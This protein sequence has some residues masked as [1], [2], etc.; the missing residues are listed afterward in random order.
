MDL[1]RISNGF[2]DLYTENLMKKERRSRKLRTDRKRKIPPE[3][4]PVNIKRSCQVI[5]RNTTDLKFKDS[6]S[7]EFRDYRIR[8]TQ[9]LLDKWRSFDPKNGIQRIDPT[10]K[11]EFH[12]FTIDYTQVTLPRLLEHINNCERAILHEGNF[13]QNRQVLM[14][15]AHVL[16]KAGR[17]WL[18]KKGWIKWEAFNNQDEQDSSLVIAREKTRRHTIM[19]K[20]PNDSSKIIETREVEEPTGLEFCHGY[21]I[22]WKDDTF[23]ALKDAGVSDEGFPWRR[24]YDSGKRLEITT[25]ESEH[26]YE[27]CE[28][29]PEARKKLIQLG[30][31]SSVL[32]QDSVGGIAIQGS[33]AEAAFLGIDDSEM[34]PE[35]LDFARESKCHEEKRR[36]V[37]R[38]RDL[39]RSRPGQKRKSPYSR[40][41]GG[42]VST[43]TKQPT[44][45]DLESYVSAKKRKQK[46]KQ[47]TAVKHH[48][49]EK[50]G[51]HER[52]VADLN[53]LHRA[54]ISV[55]AKRGGVKSGSFRTHKNDPAKPYIKIALGYIQSVTDRGIPINVEEVVAGKHPV[56]NYRL[57][58]EAVGNEKLIPYCL[59]RNDPK[60]PERVTGFSLN[61]RD[62]LNGRLLKP[63]S[64]DKKDREDFGDFAHA[65]KLAVLTR[66]YQRLTSFEEEESVSTDVTR[67]DLFLVSPSYGSQ[68]D[69][70]VLSESGLLRATR[71]VLRGRMNVT[72]FSVLDP[73]TKLL[74][75][76]AQLAR[77]HSNGDIKPGDIVG[78]TAPGLRHIIEKEDLGCYNARFVHRGAENANLLPEGMEFALVRP[79]NTREKTKYNNR[80]PSPASVR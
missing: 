21:G 50:L 49:K 63:V 56:V 40:K 13:T 10:Y 66:N 14:Y 23:D 45:A 9:P 3:D 46:K 58:K 19:T 41:K 43:I 47:K 35:Y 71:N 60:D 16:P 64:D 55:Y 62:L 32:E 65:V 44:E 28:G 37:L 72:D 78:L 24:A 39:R 67:T 34:R 31:V 6:P 4:A 36:T 1:D 77:D 5:R 11:H 76:Y 59:E 79:R 74:L 70:Y 26:L 2:G 38:R 61:L 17:E 15:L 54:G 53:S 29:H 80:S 18:L 30:L 68:P 75:E 52:Y 8:A 22:N 42:V 12:D 69:K 48:E 33:S 51:K 27:L 25:E 7:Q 73:R 57:L 20:D